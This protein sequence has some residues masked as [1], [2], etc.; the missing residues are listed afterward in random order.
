ATAAAILL[1]L[2][3][4]IAVS[5]WQ[6]IRASHSK[7]A[8]IAAMEAE[9]EQRREAEAQRDR[10]LKAE[11]RSQDAKKRADDEAATAKA[12]NEFLREDLLCQAGSGDQIEKGFQA[13][14]NL[15]VKT[16]LNR[17][18]ARIGDRFKDK[19][20]VEAA[21]RLTIAGAYQ[22]IGENHLAVS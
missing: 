17:A 9:A 15:T 1:L 8:A 10:A 3:G 20:L 22:G 13:D 7:T 2:A 18:A 14:P 5:A 11:K 16:A 4:G 12:V 21:V 19:P 6:A